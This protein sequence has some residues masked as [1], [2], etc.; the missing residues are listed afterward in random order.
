MDSFYEYL[1]KAYVLFGR[2][3]FW[4]MFQ[5]AYI[6]VQKYFRH[7]PWYYNHT[8]SGNFGFF[9]VVVSPSSQAV[10]LIIVSLASAVLIFSS[11]TKITTFNFV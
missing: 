11:Q 4:K 7:G 6:A 8:L 2:D 1:M 10:N 5:S 3:E 9:V